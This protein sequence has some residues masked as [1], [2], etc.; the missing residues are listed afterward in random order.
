MPSSP[1]TDLERA[2]RRLN[3]PISPAM[4][5][6]KIPHS[7]VAPHQ[8]LQ[9]P[10]NL[11]AFINIM[12]IPAAD[13]MQG[14]DTTC[15]TIVTMVHGFSP[16]PEE[17][18]MEAFK[19]HPVPHEDLSMAG[20]FCCDFL[21]NSRNDALDPTRKIAAQLQLLSQHVSEN[22][23][24]TYTTNLLVTKALV[25]LTS[26][27]LFDHL[28]NK[29]ESETIIS[30][31]LEAGASFLLHHALHI[32]SV[33][34]MSLPRQQYI[35]D[36]LDAIGTVHQSEDADRRNTAVN[37]MLDALVAHFHPSDVTTVREFNLLVKDINPIIGGTGRAIQQNNIRIVSSHAFNSPSTLDHGLELVQQTVVLGGEP[38]SL[39]KVFAGVALDM[40]R[41]AFTVHKRV[42]VQL[43]DGLGKGY[44]AVI[45]WEG[46]CEFECL[47]QLL[48]VFRSILWWGELFGIN[49]EDSVV[50]TVCEG[51][52]TTNK[53]SVGLAVWTRA[54][55]LVMLRRPN[56]G[57][58]ENRGASTSESGGSWYCAMSAAAIPE[59]TS[60][61]GKWAWTCD[62]AREIELGMEHDCVGVWTA[63]VL[64]VVFFWLLN[65]AV[66][67]SVVGRWKVEV[68]KTRRVE[69]RESWRGSM[70]SS[71]AN[72]M[73]VVGIPVE[74]NFNAVGICG[75]ALHLVDS[76]VV[77]LEGL[78][79]FRRAALLAFARFRHNCK[80]RSGDGKK[81]WGRLLG[82]MIQRSWTQFGP[83][84]VRL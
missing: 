44:L 37:S 35:T 77:R 29:S 10:F 82:H 61:S 45:D 83:R 62:S 51:L 36:L 18:W 15:D 79:P 78:Y 47:E 65:I 48:V 16:W 42:E 6:H 50:R 34:E 7:A 27:F 30:M 39:C 17:H 1:T 46:T 14:W 4:K 31:A 80:R 49:A 70:S 11:Q 73:L 32:N 41:P 58:G 81:A 19:V 8:Q 53:V 71:E 3:V 84:S 22:S 24:S 9:H 13:M 2:R 59:G 12:K 76:A 52:T 54:A 55:L 57:A 72:W 64:I 69:I 21:E 28:F 56:R 5:D 63:Q 66:H 67:S 20:K 26:D 40:C 38:A 60:S 75:L 74:R 43:P 23:L 68:R 25:K 33:R